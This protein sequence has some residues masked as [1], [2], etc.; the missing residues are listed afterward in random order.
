MRMKAAVYTKYGPPER[1]Q[2][3]EVAQPTPQNHEVLVKVYAATVNR[4]DCG[5]L[6]RKP[7][8]A[9]LLYGLRRPK[10]TILGNEFAGRVAAVGAEVAL[11]RV[12]DDVFG[13]NDATFGAHAEY[14]VMPGDGMLAAMPANVTH[15]AAAPTAEGAHYALNN[16]RAARVAAGQRVLIHGAGGAI[17]SAAVQLAKHFGTEVT[18][19]CAARHVELARSLGADRV[20][21]YAKEDFTTSGPAYDFV[22]D[23]VGKSS[24]G[25]CRTL[26]KPGGRY[27]STELGFLWQNLLLALWTARFGGKKVILPSP[28][29]RATDIA[30]LK[31]LVAAGAFPPVIDRRYPLEE[32]VAAFRYV[33]T[34]RKTGNVVL[35]LASANEPR[36]EDGLRPNASQATA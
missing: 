20:V 4:T 9:R 2:V 33:E 17:G 32:I 16:L 18:A 23:A 22:F 10:H 35:T 29:A 8:F 7:C 26:L 25:A 27:C 36:R 1:L 5:A 24:F 14:L 30:V 13:Y 6:R 34:G 12:G 31:E 11:F 28:R 15:D 19:V 21:D 3:K